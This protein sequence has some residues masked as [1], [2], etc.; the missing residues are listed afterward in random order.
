MAEEASALL[1][2]GEQQDSRNKKPSYDLLRVD[3]NWVESCSDK[4]ELLKAFEA[5]KEDG[6]FPDLQKTVA[7]KIALIDPSLRFRV[8]GD[9]RVSFEE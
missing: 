3:Y 2:P 4:K 6:G 1:N 7:K 9:D 8:L 5:L